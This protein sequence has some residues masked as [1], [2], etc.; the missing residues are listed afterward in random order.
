MQFDLSFVYV[1]VQVIFLEG[2]FS[3]DNAA[4]LDAMVSVLSKEKGV[5]SGF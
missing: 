3:I 2:I 5:L 1:T 4:V